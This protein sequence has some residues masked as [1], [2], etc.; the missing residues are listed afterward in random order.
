VRRSWVQAE[1]EIKKISHETYGIGVPTRTGPQAYLRGI[2]SWCCSVLWCI[3]AWGISLCIRLEHF[4]QRQVLEIGT[5]S[6]G[7]VHCTPG[8]NVAIGF[9]MVSDDYLFDVNRTTSYN[10]AIHES[11]SSSASTF[12]Y[13]HSSREVAQKRRFWII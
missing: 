13:G 12:S 4:S 1:V 7:T 3:I 5:I 2:C 11:S 10:K 8:E 6:F 9:C